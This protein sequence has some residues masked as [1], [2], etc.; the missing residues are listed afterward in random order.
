MYRN[1]N[2]RPVR[3]I[4]AAMASPRRPRN[5]I[6]LIAVALTTFMMFA[7]SSM[8]VNDVTLSL[9]SRDAAYFARLCVTVGVLAGFMMLTGYLVIYNIMNISVNGDV[10]FYGL[11]KT[12]GATPRQIAA[13]VRGQAFIVGLIGIPAGLALGG[14]MVHVVMPRFIGSLIGA[15][16]ADVNTNPWALAVAAAFS[17]ATIAVS[18]RKPARIAAQLAP[19]EA[20]RHT[21]Y[22]AYT[23]KKRKHAAARRGN[24]DSA[25]TGAARRSKAFSL[26]SF[27]ARNVTREKRKLVI[28]TL[29]LFIGVATFLAA[30]T[31]ITALDV[32]NYIAY[33]HADAMEVREFL[34]A[35]FIVK[36]FGIGVFAV[37]F[38]IGVMNFVNVMVAE[39][40]A[41]RR[42]L[43]VME[44]VGMTERQLR[45]ALVCEGLTYAGLSIAAI[46]T[47]GNALI[48]AVG[49]QASNLV[50]WAQ[51]RY[52]AGPVALIVCIIVAICA[53][54]PQIVYSAARRDSVVERLRM[55]E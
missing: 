2:A 31:L 21:G 7:V 24:C 1:N 52:P 41:R 12:I 9:I 20:V 26:F 4:A 39:V 54:T 43:A 11:L 45:G 17:L 22:A 25:S 37:L 44:S 49:G 53:V 40:L 14:L 38:L 55:A 32:D 34:S 46:L 5:V 50:E 23:G 10:R 18:L 27:A 16:G 13:A 3:R 42:E 15:E 29:S 36:A 28:V 8:A 51:F 48:F 19:A 33:F 47:L 35:L 30:E 6:M